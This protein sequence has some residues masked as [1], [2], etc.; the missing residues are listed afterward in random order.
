MDYIIIIVSIVLAFLLG[1]SWFKFP[2]QRKMLAGFLAGI[3]GAAAAYFLGKSQQPSLP[4][5]PKHQPKP[6]KEQPKHHIENPH[7]IPKIINPPNYA[8]GIDNAKPNDDVYDHDPDAQSKD[9]L[10]AREAL[11]W[12]DATTGSHD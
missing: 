10:D 11:E 1:W 7:P 9:E 5:K 6:E 12:F 8:E 2:H 3:V 4:D